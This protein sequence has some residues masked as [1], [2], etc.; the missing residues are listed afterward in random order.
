MP[1]E[2]KPASDE[3]S[4]KPKE[5]LSLVQRLS[6]DLASIPP[7]AKLGSLSP[8]QVSAVLYT[9][10]V[11]SVVGTAD[12]RT[13]DLDLFNAKV[14]R[15]QNSV[16]TRREA[17]SLS[18]TLDMTREEQTL[19]IQAMKTNKAVTRAISEGRL[20]GTKAEIAGLVDALIQTVDIYP[21]NA[22]RYLTHHVGLLGRTVTTVELTNALGLTDDFTESELQEREADGSHRQ[23]DLSPSLARLILAADLAGVPLQNPVTDMVY[24]DAIDAQISSIPVGVRLH[25]LVD[26]PDGPIRQKKIIRVTAD[27]TRPPTDATISPAETGQFPSY[28]VDHVIE[29]TKQ[30]PDWFGMLETGVR[31]AI[32]ATAGIYI[33]G[34][35]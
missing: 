18:A 21:P 5:E 20:D 3:L 29:A 19:I 27:T 2:L 1:P 25:G 15:I 26:S 11:E 23:K 6:A 7:Y 32:L 22:L 35:Y 14:A 16:V 12:F 8:D 33:D 31:S 24:I 34:E 13:V 9:A 30:R 10:S 28:K 4:P 17:A